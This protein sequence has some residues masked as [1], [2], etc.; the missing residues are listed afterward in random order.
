MLAVIL[1]AMLLGLPAEELPA[2]SI[3]LQQ[4]QQE[5]AHQEV[6]QQESATA[7][8]DAGAP[9]PPVLPVSY[10]TSTP[11]CPDGIKV[12]TEVPGAVQPGEEEMAARCL[13]FAPSPPEPPS[14]PPSAPPPS[15]PPPPPP[16]PPHP[17]PPPP[18]PPL[19]PP[20]PT[21]PPPCYDQSFTVYWFEFSKCTCKNGAYGTGTG[22]CGAGGNPDGSM[23]DCYAVRN[24]P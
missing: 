15:S 14:L 4:G 9:S 12:V 21:P 11:D 7:D 13:R 2:R 20:P 1:G 22:G 16:P 6:A 18:P 24:N 8:S 3:V 10:V 23:R 5:S 17:P 19:H